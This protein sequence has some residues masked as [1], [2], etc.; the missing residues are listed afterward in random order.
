M[1]LKIDQLVK[2]YK[3]EEKVI[4]AAISKVS[5]EVISQNEKVGKQTSSQEK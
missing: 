5:K 3:T 1:V 4:I 2:T